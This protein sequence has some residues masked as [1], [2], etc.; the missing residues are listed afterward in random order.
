MTTLAEPA[1]PA[2]PAIHWHQRPYVRAIGVYLLVRAFGVAMLALFTAKTGQSLVE[3]LTSWDGQWYLDLANHGY[4]GITRGLYDAAGNYEPNTPLA[5]FPAY[6][7]LLRAVAP[8]TLSSTVLAGFLVSAVAGCLAAAAIFRLARLVDGRDRTGVLLVALWAGAPMAITLSMTYTEALFTAFAAWALV[9]VVERR[10]LLAALCCV[11]AGLT[12]PTATVLV[13]VV[14]LAALIAFFRTRDR[15]QTMA[16]VVLC[17]L[18][19]F[20]FW[21]WVAI[22]IGKPTGWWD[23]ERNNWWTRFDGGREAAKFAWDKLVPGSSVMETMTVFVL[24]AAAVLAVLLFRTMRPLAQWWPLA[25]YGAGMLVLVVGTAGLP[26][27]KIRFLL[28]GFILLFPVAR[29]LASRRPGTAVAT[30]AGFVVLGSW[31]SA[32]ALT[33]WHYTI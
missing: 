2:R 8:V 7:M 12:R 32:Y 24:L 29:G 23:L 31:F 27:A 3:R 1:A 25:A 20:G 9:G 4:F 16:C 28:P 5:F 33:G 26:S 6:P 30:V 19:L 18:G 15:W 22:N 14:G 17:P 10:W 21:T 11:A 13:C